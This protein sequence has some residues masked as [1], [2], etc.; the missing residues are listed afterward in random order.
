MSMEALIVT[1]QFCILVTVM[2]TGM[3]TCDKTAYDVHRAHTITDKS[4]DEVWVNSVDCTDISFLVLDI[5]RGM[6]KSE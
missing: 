4:T 3:Y 5:N 1:K 2:A 6:G